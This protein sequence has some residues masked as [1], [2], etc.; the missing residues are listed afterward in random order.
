MRQIIFAAI[1]GFTIASA[2]AAAEPVVPDTATLCLDTIGVNHPPVCHTL[3][4]SRINTQPD[5]C[6]CLGPWRHVTASWCAPNEKAPAESHSYEV[7]RL[8]HARKHKDSIVG[9]TYDGKPMCVRPG[10][11]P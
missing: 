11:G 3:S 7:A 8:D 6:Q 1:A 10:N 5:I 2:A 4:A 9:A